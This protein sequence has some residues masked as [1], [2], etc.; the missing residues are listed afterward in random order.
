MSEKTVLPCGC[1]IWEDTIDRAVTLIFEPHALDC[2][3]YLFFI[4]ESAR[5]DK[6]VTTID[7]R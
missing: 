4:A 2:K 3:H 5:Q 7:A 6:P 1:R